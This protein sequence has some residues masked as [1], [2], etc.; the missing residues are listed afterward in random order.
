MSTLSLGPP[1]VAAP[2][3]SGPRPVVPPTAIETARAPRPI[4]AAARGD[5]LRNPSARERPVGPPPAFEVSVLEDMRDRLRQAAEVAPT[6]PDTP[7]EP[8]T[9]EVEDPPPTQT[10]PPA[11]LDKKV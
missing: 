9:A 8:P 1:P 6:P 2:I 4:E 10:E 3:V 5:P 11:H 7:V